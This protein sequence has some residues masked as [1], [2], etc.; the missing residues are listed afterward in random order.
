MDH[1]MDALIMIKDRF[2][3]GCQVRRVDQDMYWSRKQVKL[4]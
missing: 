3:V 2:K 4:I 1:H